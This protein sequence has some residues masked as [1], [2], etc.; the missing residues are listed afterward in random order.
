MILIQKT[1]KNDLQHRSK[2]DQKSIKKT[3]QKITG[4]WSEKWPKSD[5][6]MD[7]KIVQQSILGPTWPPRGAQENPRGLQRPNLDDFWSIWDRILTVFGPIWDR[8]WTD[9]DRFATTFLP[10]ISSQCKLLKHVV[11]GI[12]EAF[13]EW[14]ERSSEAIAYFAFGEPCQFGKR[15]LK[16]RRLTIEL[17]LDNVGT[18]KASKPGKQQHG[19]LGKLQLGTHKSNTWAGGTRE[20]ITI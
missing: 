19:Q 3:I 5:S 16:D 13:S 6:K 18:W 4:F 2:F 17:E 11:S 10:R 9:L 20:A 15:H 1:S 14:I 12:A 8:I 7:P